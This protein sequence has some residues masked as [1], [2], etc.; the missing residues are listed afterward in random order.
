LFGFDGAAEWPGADRRR[1]PDRPPNGLPDRVAS[2]HSQSKNDAAIGLVFP[3]LFS[4]GVLLINL[5]ARDVH[6]DQHAVLLGEIGF[7][8]LDTL[9]IGPYRVPQSLLSLGAMT[10]VNFTF[11]ALFYKNLS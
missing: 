9:Q 2:Q 6:I 4:I 7:V 1:G 8:W 5:Y 10:L 11:V 3:V